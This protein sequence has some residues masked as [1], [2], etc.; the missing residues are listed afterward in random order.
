MNKKL[1]I[2]LTSSISA[3]TFL[4]FPDAEPPPLQLAASAG[5]SYWVSVPVASLIWAFTIP[6]SSVGRRTFDQYAV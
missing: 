2:I 5:I 6:D 4:A 3:F 1:F